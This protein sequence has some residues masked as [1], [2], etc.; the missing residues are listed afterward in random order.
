MVLWVEERNA[1]VC[2]D[3][4]VDFGD[5]FGIASWLRG[6]VTRDKIVAGKHSCWKIRRG[7]TPGTATRRPSRSER[8]SCGR[9]PRGRDGPDVDQSKANSG[10]TTTTTVAAHTAKTGR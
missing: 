10:G 1:V 5:G 7:L 6:E 4:L 8:V 2:G 3:A 9:R